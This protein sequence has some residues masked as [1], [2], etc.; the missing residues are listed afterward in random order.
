MKRA[1]IVVAAGLILAVVLTNSLVSVADPKS[2]GKPYKPVQN[3]ER[4]M[5]S[6]KK[7]MQDIKTCIDE[8]SWRDGATSA[9]ILAEMA[10]SNHYQRDDAAYQKFADDMSGQ[11]V[12]L[13]KLMKKADAGACKEQVNKIGKTCNAC[14]D[15][16][17]KRR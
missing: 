15:Q 13:A 4:M 2:S 7:I 17:K 16:F 6:Q 12:E 14:H 1:R 11:C 8:K 5:G 3:V 10:N 9:W